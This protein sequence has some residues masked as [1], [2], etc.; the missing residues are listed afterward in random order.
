M[1]IKNT[2]GFAVNNNIS[3]NT[4]ISF[5]LYVYVYKYFLSYNN[6]KIF[7]TIAN[8]SLFQAS[9]ILS[10]ATLHFLAKSSRT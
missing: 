5:S 3:F 7:S 10:L 9:D 2:T 4:L 8:F 6:Y 1:L